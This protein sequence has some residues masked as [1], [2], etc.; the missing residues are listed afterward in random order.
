MEW[1][2][3]S[4]GEFT[5]ALLASGGVVVA[6]YL[7]KQQVRRASVPTL[8]LWEELLRTRERAALSLR[9]RSVFSVLLAL[10]IVA[11]LLLALA[12]LRRHFDGEGRTLVLL[13]DTSGSMSATDEAPTRL[14][15][16]KRAAERFVRALA[17]ADRAMVVA[18]GAQ[19]TPLGGFRAEASELLIDL[20][21][22]HPTDGSADLR[23]GLGLAADVLQGQ[24]HPEVLLISDGNVLGLPEAT[25]LATRLQGLRV[26]SV[27][28]GKSA[29][30]FGITS[31][32]V[33]RY[34]LDRTHQECMVTVTSYAERPERVA[35]T[36]SASGTLL[37][38]ETLTLEP[39]AEQTRMLTDLPAGE[40]LL[41]AKLTPVAG[42]DT[43]PADDVAWTAL[44]PRERTR[45]LVVSEGNR[46]LEA[47]LLLDEYLDVRESSP[48]D[49]LQTGD[50]EVVIFDRVRPEADPGI[51]ALYLGPGE[52]SGFFPLPVDGEVARPFFDRVDTEH[53]SVRLIALRDVNVARAA[54]TTPAPGDTVIAGTSARVPLIVEGRR[55]APFIALTFDARL[56]DLPLR[57]AWPLFLL[58]SIEHLSTRSEDAASSFRAGELVQLVVPEG[59][60]RVSITPPHGAPR[61]VATP[62]ASLR[63]LAEL[64]GPYTIRAADRTWQ[65]AVNVPPGEGRIAPQAGSFARAEPPVL[66]EAPGPGFGERPWPWFAAMALLLVALEWF[67]FHR[68]WTV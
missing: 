39:G 50:A 20:A 10:A 38:E 25:Q 68:R 8:F 16:A 26:R 9:L 18:L 31:F 6:L 37:H 13:L 19:A 34:P 17:P 45:V 59:T 15:A 67:T 14:E 33:R 57:P 55:Q 44:P 23:S 64:A 61:E 21:A 4:A 27:S 63:F 65:V 32:A 66:A 5:L 41:E 42:P 47:A 49:A 56:S 53:P 60:Q 48:R 7:L 46:Y 43:L 29:R 24:P 11:L 2:G 52:G 28:V 12:D 54:R 58:S 51:P 22:L 1:L 40:A 36:I 3:L 30:N 35:L 62:G